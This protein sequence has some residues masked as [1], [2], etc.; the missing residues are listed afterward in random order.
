MRLLLLEHDPG[1]G[2][3][4][5]VLRWAS[6]RGHAVEVLEVFTGAPFPEQGRFDWLMVMGGS[7]HAWDE[8]GT[9][10]LGP[11]KAFLSRTLGTGKRVLGICFG[12]QL[13]AEALGGRVFP[14]RF[15]EIGWHWVSLTPEGR[16]SPLFQGIPDPFLSFHWHS[17]GFS[18]PPGCRRLASSAATETQ[19]FVLPG[20]PVVGLQFHPEITRELA[21][22]F[23]RRYGDLWVRGPWVPGPEETLRATEGVPDTSWLLDALLDPMAAGSP[24]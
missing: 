3:S 19:A 2:P 20:R 14:N 16:A 18:L 6:E 8:E 11:E 1:S 24:F 13:L 21:T 23:A 15:Q 4:H 10:W 22:H 17:D 12:A 7:Q 5:D 9:P